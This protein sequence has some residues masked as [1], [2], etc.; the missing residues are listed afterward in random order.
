VEIEIGDR[1]MSV[2]EMYA[3]EMQNLINDIVVL[4]KMHNQISI[5]EVNNETSISTLYGYDLKINE[6]QS[7]CFW[8]DKQSL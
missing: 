1:K 6:K 3:E 8:F 5:K 7:I 4:S 2:K